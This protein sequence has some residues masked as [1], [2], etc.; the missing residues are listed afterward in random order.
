MKTLTIILLATIGMSATN[1]YTML[2]CVGLVLLLTIKEL[3]K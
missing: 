2:I 3:K 1:F